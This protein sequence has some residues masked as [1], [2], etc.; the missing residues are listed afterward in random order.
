[1][2]VEWLVRWRG[3]QIGLVHFR[4]GMLDGVS[5]EMGK[6]RRALEQLGHRVTVVA[7]E[8]PTGEA[9][10]IPELSIAGAEG[11]RR[12]AFAALSAP[13]KNSPRRSSGRPDASRGSSWTR[14]GGR[15]LTS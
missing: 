4:Y 13:L 8:D 11:I 10:V 7:G 14:C 6:W 12:D 5:L 3:M 9:T 15:G 1:M 2:D